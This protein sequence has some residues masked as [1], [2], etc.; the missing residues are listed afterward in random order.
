VKDVFHWDDGN[1]QHFRHYR[2]AKD[3]DYTIRNKLWEESMH[4]S[5]KAK[6]I[7]EIE[8]SPNKWK[9]EQRD[10]YRIF[11]DG[12]T[13]DE[14]KKP[15]QNLHNARADTLS[16]Q[17]TSNNTLN[18]RQQQ[19]NMIGEH[20]NN[21]QVGSQ[22][23]MNT[24]HQEEIPQAASAT[25]AQEKDH[26]RK[27]RINKENIN[28]KRP[29]SAKQKAKPD[30]TRENFKG[31]TRWL[32]DSAFTTYFGKPAF[33]SYGMANINPVNGGNIY[34]QYMLSHNINPESGNNL[35]QYQ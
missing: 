3:Q 17:K 10:Q 27:V 23:L 7:R 25:T 21:I 26:H 33:H 4:E 5:F 11:V 30:P 22:A 18:D 12:K 9:S 16:P 34:G 15:K 29:Q 14:M 35:P 32:P 31:P 8:R 2:L 19:E 1:S 20:L 13:A 24:Q 6:K 28:K